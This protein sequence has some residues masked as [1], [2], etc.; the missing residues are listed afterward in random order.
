MVKTKVVLLTQRGRYFQEHT[1][2]EAERF[3]REFRSQRWA[4]LS[5]R[6]A[7][8]DGPLVTPS[9]ETAAEITQDGWKTLLWMELACLLQTLALGSRVPCG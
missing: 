7:Q 4:D 2:A 3:L 6:G 5:D 9:V 1:H 8:G